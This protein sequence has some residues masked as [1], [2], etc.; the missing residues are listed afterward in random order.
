MKK[1]FYTLSAVALLIFNC[2]TLLSAQKLATSETLKTAANSVKEKVHLHLDKP[3]Y[4]AG[5]HIWLKAYVVEYA[6]HK[7]SSNSGVLYVDLINER[8]QLVRQLKLPVKGGTTWGNF[9]LPDTLSTG[10]YRLRAYTQ[11]MRNSGSSYFYQQQL[12]IGNI[13][14]NKLFTQTSFIKEGTAAKNVLANIKVLD[15]DGKP[16]QG[17]KFTY[18]IYLDEKKVSEGSAVANNSGEIGLSFE[19]PK[20]TSSNFA[21]YISI[22]TVSNGFTATKTIPIIS[23]STALD[24]QFL[25][26]GGNLVNGLPCKIGVKVLNTRGLGENVMGNIVDN[27]GNEITTFETTYLGMGNCVL[28]PDASKTYIA[29][30]KD[31]NGNLNSFTLPKVLQSGYQL[32]ANALDSAK[33]D[34]KVLISEAILNSGELRLIAQRLGN[35]LFEI[36]VSTQRQI[37][38]VSI[39]RTRLPSGTIQLTLFNDKGIAVSERIVFNYNPITTINLVASGLKSSYGSKELVEVNILASNENQPTLG[40]FSVTVT[41]ATTVASNED[42]ESNIWASFLLKA[43]TSGFIEKPNA[44]FSVNNLVSRERLDNLMLTQAWRKLDWVSPATTAEY[45]AETGITIRGTVTTMS[46]KP[47]AKANVTLLFPNNKMVIAST[48]ADENGF[49]KFE[50]IYLEDEN[51]FIIQAATPEG[52]KNLDVILE[53]VKPEAIDRLLQPNI[54]KDVNLSLLGYLNANNHYLEQ[55]MRAGF[56]E[57]TNL[58]KTVEV[59]GKKI[60]NEDKAAP[61]SSNYNGRG[62]ADQVV[63]GEDLGFIPSLS[64]YIKQG[65][66]RGVLDSAGYAINSRSR[67]SEDGSMYHPVLSV[68]ID[69]IIIQNFL[70]EN[71]PVSDIESIEV[72][73]NPAL[74]TA[75]GTTVNDGLLVVSTKRGKGLSYA[76]I[77]TPGLVASKLI[78]YTPA[79]QFYSPKYDVKKDEPDQR[80]TTYWNPQIVTDS[81]GNTSFSFYNADNKGLHRIV[82]EGI[83]AEGNLARRVLT[84]EVK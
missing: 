17:T 65:R 6:F 12:K 36:P 66:I 22:S 81:K 61:H 9:N 2:A 5:D 67:M 32:T 43:E 33:I 35:V 14:T 83:D 37:S 84:Y 42:T 45:V 11:L 60:T 47:V 40:S 24:A 1:L 54:E 53:K 30:I 34:L 4:A 79:K 44:Y 73:V 38:T 18:K 49:F 21:P 58:L 41:N 13:L 31:S 76:D 7:P 48:E 71:I 23:V 74:L 39:P 62:R 3:Y 64:D 8:Q 20:P 75:Y 25:P 70:L 28:T 59:L 68:A 56:L 16:Q 82:I 63:T 15:K 51:K 52:K 29:K 50:N 78:G 57:R 26:E 77:R 10:N 46:K 19:E 80:T 27:E 72:L 69:G 55:Q